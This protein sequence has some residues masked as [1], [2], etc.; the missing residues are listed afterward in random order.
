MNCMEIGDKLIDYM[1]GRLNGAEKE[2]IGLHMEGC[3][4]C[5]R[6]YE[7]MLEAIGYVQDSFE[8]INA[9]LGFMNKSGYKANRQA[10][11]R[12]RK[13]LKTI[14]ISAALILV[15]TITAFAA[16]GFDIIS[17]WRDLSIKESKSI[18]ELIAEGYGERVNKAAEDQNIKFTIETVVADDTCTIL[19]YSI[20]DLNKEKK[21]LLNEFM[22][23]D[24]IKGE[25]DY[26]YPGQS[27]P[28][29]TDASLYSDVPYIQRGM[30]RLEPIK[31]QSG[32]ISITI[33]KLL[34]GD[35]KPFSSIQGNWNL[36]IPVKKYE[37]KIYTLNREVD[38]DGIKVTFKELK[39]APT[40]TALTYSY[41]ENQKGYKI[42][43]FFDIRLMAGGK[44][45]KRKY[46]GVDSMSNSERTIEFDSMYLDEPDKINLSVG[47]YDADVY[48]Y[49][50]Y[51]I[52]T[53]KS[54]PQ[55]FD[56]F[57]CKIS[58]DDIKI[59]EGKTE[60]ILSQIF[61]KNKYEN[62]NVEFA[63]KDI[64]LVKQTYFF[65]N[66][67]ERIIFDRYG[68]KVDI[69][70]IDVEEYKK[71]QPKAY[72]IKQKIL[73]EKRSGIGSPPKEYHINKLIPVQLKVQGYRDTRY[74]N[75]SFTL[76]LDD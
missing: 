67:Y 7:G 44:E 61:G 48:Q 55:V 39:I 19:S 72:I 14:L 4:E 43:S 56:Y 66:Q 10:A 75:E 13:P 50:Y 74:V 27:S 6:E 53:N 46:M 28:Y 24:L 25:F 32:G 21:Y 29:I 31:G 41:N 34:Y 51:D 57:G 18:E 47:G 63:V 26:S 15:F 69:N 54:F 20:E 70:E 3:K 37:S 73:L 62:I 68:R 2:N 9:P 38:I 42:R 12:M 16:G 30:I 64:Q 52:D 40:N 71:L 22:K 60:V 5:R 8:K 36:N 59:E 1:D 33:R 76:Q 23:D 11:V 65:D 49:A 45:Y 58:I 17:W 35:K